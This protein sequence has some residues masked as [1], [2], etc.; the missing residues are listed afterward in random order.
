MSKKVLSI[1]DQYTIRRHVA[2]ALEEVGI[3]IMEAA[4]PAVAAQILVRHHAEIGLIILDI[5]MPRMNGLDFL[6]S[7]K[8]HAQFSGIPVIMMTTENQTN[9]VMTAVKEGAAGYIIKPFKKED[10]IHKVQENILP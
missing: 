4:D 10:L 8:R 9:A 5:N 1:D 2:V 3:D 7:L 6:A